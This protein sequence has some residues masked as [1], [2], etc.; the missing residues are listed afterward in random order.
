MIERQTNSADNLHRLP[1][2]SK[3]GLVNEDGKVV[4]MF[5]EPSHRESDQEIIRLLKNR[6][7]EGI[8]KLYDQ[9]SPNIYGVVFN[10]L[11]NEEAAFDVLRSTFTKIWTLSESTDFSK[12]T[13][14]VWVLGIACREAAVLSGTT[15]HELTSLIFH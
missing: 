12:R 14:R 6:N 11:K 3:R 5:S 15:S 8:S 9:F 4:S 10:I 2:D 1:H 7:E 13:F